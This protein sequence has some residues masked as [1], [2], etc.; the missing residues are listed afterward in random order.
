MRNIYRNDPFN[1]YITKVELIHPINLWCHRKK[2]P[3]GGDTQNLAGEKERVGINGLVVVVPLDE[4]SLMVKMTH[5]T[6]T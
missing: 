6:D 4:L 1:K 3:K 5:Q 2:L